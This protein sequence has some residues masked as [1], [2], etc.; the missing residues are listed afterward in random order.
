MVDDKWEGVVEEVGLRSTRIRTF[1]KSMV[2]VPNAKV[3]NSPINNMGQRPFR[4]Q[5]T[6]IGIEYGTPPA[7]V[8]A[9]VARMNRI[10]TDHPQ[11]WTDTLEIH[12]KDFGA[13]SL[14]ILVYFFINVPDWHQ[15]L[16]VRQEIFLA[17]M[18]AAEEMGVNFAFPSTSLYI[19]KMPQPS[20]P[21]PA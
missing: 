19:E 12:F 20:L 15:E 21:R 11:T 17:F 6:T 8:E 14:D 7:V 2:S 5:M 13:S 16:K 18:T 9:Y 3:G 1:G 10:V 4:R